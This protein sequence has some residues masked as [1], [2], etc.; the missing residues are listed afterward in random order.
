MLISSLVLLNQLIE[1]FFQIEIIF[2]GRVMLKKYLYFAKKSDS[3]FFADLYLKNLETYTSVLLE[4]LEINDRFG[5]E[6]IIFS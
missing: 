4:I 2:L 5:H 1:K 6:N 3:N